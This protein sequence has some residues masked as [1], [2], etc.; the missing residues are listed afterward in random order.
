[1]IGLGKS[2]NHLKDLYICHKCYFDNNH[3]QWGVLTKGKKDVKDVAD[4]VNFAKKT[5]RYQDDIK[6]ALAYERSDDL[7]TTTI[8]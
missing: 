5:L 7:T 1:V 4:F 6:V 3:H 8:T 2:L